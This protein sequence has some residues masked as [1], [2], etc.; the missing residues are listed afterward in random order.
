[1]I[2]TILSTTIA[3]SVSSLLLVGCGS[4]VQKV[5]KKRD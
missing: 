5:E 2:K 1:M 4:T 3:I